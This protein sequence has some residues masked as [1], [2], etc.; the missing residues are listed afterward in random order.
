VVRELHGNHGVPPSAL[1]GVW[2]AYTELCTLFVLFAAASGVYL[3][4]NRGRERRFGFA[5]LGAAAVLSLVFMA[6][7][8]YG[9]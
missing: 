6:Y 2:A 5:V 9:G 8:R 3:F 4:A 1:L 7:V